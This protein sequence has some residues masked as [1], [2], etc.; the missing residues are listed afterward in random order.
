MFPGSVSI[1]APEGRQARKTDGVF[2]RTAVCRSVVM[3]QGAVHSC[4]F[5]VL[6]GRSVV[7]GVWF[8]TFLLFPWC[9]SVHFPS[10]FRDFRS[11]FGQRRRV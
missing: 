11:S 6:K 1:E 10:T 5:T 3:R 2:G 7:F 8:V 4:D 9:F